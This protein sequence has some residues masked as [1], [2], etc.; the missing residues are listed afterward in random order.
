MGDSVAEEFGDYLRDD[1]GIKVLFGKKKM[2][3]SAPGTLGLLP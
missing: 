1:L 2:R 3:A